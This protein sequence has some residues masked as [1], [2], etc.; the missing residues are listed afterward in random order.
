[1]LIETKKSY[2]ERSTGFMSDLMN[3]KGID[4][5]EKDGVAYLKLETVARGLGF[6]R[7]ATSGNEVIRWERVKK[8]L[9][10]IGFM[11][12]SGYDIVTEF[13]PENIF[14]RLAMKA[15]NETA[16]KFQALVA[17]EIIPSIRKTG[18]YGIPKTTTGQIQLLAQGYMELEQKIA[19]AEKQV[20]TNTE[21]VSEV[22][23]RMEVL[24]E[25]SVVDSRQRK[26]LKS[27]GVKAVIEALGGKNSKAYK[28]TTIRGRAFVALWSDY[29]EHFDLSS[30]HD[31]TK[32]R[33]DEA[34]NYLEM[35]EPHTNLK[36]AIKS[37]NEGVA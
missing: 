27:A 36:L 30:Y 28:D 31:T 19:E 37:C 8:Y 11:P 35:W 4:C 13:I 32:A 20:A 14:Y 12:T 7:V 10:E 21:K 16:E 18:T 17:D 3:I 5:Y 1:M 34:F 25:T 2:F 24:E 6:T 9:S 22:E 15:K 23:K 26:K 33:L 29:R